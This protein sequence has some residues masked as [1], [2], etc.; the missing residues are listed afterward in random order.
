LGNRPSKRKLKEELARLGNIRPSSSDRHVLREAIEKEYQKRKAS[1]FRTQ[2]TR[3]A[4]AFFFMAM[5]PLTLFW[6]NKTNPRPD[7]VPVDVELTWY[8]EENG[9]KKIVGPAAM[10]TIVNKDDIENDRL[11]IPINL[12]IR[13]N[14]SKRLHGVKIEILYPEGSKVESNG[15]SKLSADDSTIVFQ[16]EVG[17]LEPSKYFTPIQNQSG[18]LVTIPYWFATG[19][20]IVLTKDEIPFLTEYVVPQDILTADPAVVFLLN[21]YADGRKKNT[22][23]LSVKPRIGFKAKIDFDNSE[24]Q[25]INEQ[26]RQ[27][28]ARYFLNEETAF[29]WDA[30][31]ESEI[32]TAT[33]GYREYK[34]DAGFIQRVSVNQV[35]RRLAVDSSGDGKI[36]FVILDTDADGMPDNKFIWRK[37]WPVLN[38]KKEWVVRSPKTD[39][40]IK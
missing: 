5:I 1:S 7:V 18:D 12:A 31:F 8:V 39:R 9:E 25:E 29:S 6:I 14:E 34:I 23:Q 3:M 33:I 13:S 4:L 35:L 32:Q 20:C 11:T 40:V 37:E 26:D 28:F 10:E 21:V 2:V 17:D 16:H 15:D 19:N 38:W 30:T 27:L 36:D 24:T 22:A